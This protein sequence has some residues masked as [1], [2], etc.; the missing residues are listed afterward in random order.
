MDIKTSQ[1]ELMHCK[2]SIHGGRNV[3]IG[4]NALRNDTIGNDNAVV[5]EGAMFYHESG[6]ANS[7]LGKGALRLNKIR[8]FQCDTWY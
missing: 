5:G 8:L 3:A 6:N 2:T 4:Q 1:L 7:V